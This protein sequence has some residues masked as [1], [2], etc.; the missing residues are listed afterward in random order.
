MWLEWAHGRY[1]LYNNLDFTFYCD[2]FVLAISILR[3]T[4]FIFTLRVLISFPISWN[5]MYDKIEIRI[6]GAK[7]DCPNF[8]FSVWGNLIEVVW[9]G[10]IPLSHKWDVTIFL[11][12]RITHAAGWNTK[13]TAW[14]FGVFKVYY[15]SVWSWYQYICYI[16]QL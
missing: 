15:W 1:L 11:P 12:S 9:E 8:F 5:D 4:F 2:H 7:S 10:L 13:G 3:C 16:L 6:K 14:P